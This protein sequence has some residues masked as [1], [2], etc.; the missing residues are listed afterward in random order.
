MCVGISTIYVCWY[1]HHSLQL[2]DV[3]CAVHLCTQL[4]Q[5]YEEFSE[6]LL[7]DLQRIYQNPIG[8]EDEKVRK[9][10]LN[11]VPWKYASHI[12][13]LQYALACSYHQVQTGASI[14]RRGMYMCVSLHCTTIA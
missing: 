7:S 11:I 14:C 2:A 13:P 10:T 3:G 8:K 12:Y 9:D 6:M 1:L 5:R 4:H